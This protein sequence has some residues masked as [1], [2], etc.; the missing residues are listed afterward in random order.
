MSIPSR[1]HFAWALSAALLLQGC[2]ATWIHME[3]GTVLRPGRTDFQLSMGKAP[4]VTAQCPEGKVASDGGAPVCTSFWSSRYDPSTSTWSNGSWDTTPAL[5]G[6]SLESH[7]A[8]AWSL[9]ALGPFGPFTGMEVGIQMEGPTYPISQEY[10]VTIGLPG[11]DSIWAHSLGLGWGTGMW[12]DDT[13]FAQYAASRRLKRLLVFA[14]WRSALQAT[15][16]DMSDLPTRFKHD[17]NW[18]H[19]ATCGVKFRLDDIPVVPDWMGTAVTV[20]LGHSALPNLDQSDLAQ[21][22]G[23]GVSWNFTSGWSW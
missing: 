6:A 8:T 4:V 2:I 21:P 17:R 12:S 5:V 3:D 19:Q 13:W 10:R 11:S 9:G 16:L 15:R 1:I 20:D 18:D 23:M 7:F 22:R 14:N